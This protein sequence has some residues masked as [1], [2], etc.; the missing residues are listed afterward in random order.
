M[1]NKKLTEKKLFY[2]IVCFAGVVITMAMLITES[3]AS[4]TYDIS[5]GSVSTERFVSTDTIV[6]EYATQ[7]LKDEAKNAVSPLYTHDPQVKERV[8]SG[9][10]TFFTQFDSYTSDAKTDFAD[11][12]HAYICG[13]VSLSQEQFFTLKSLSKENFDAFKNNVE[14]VTNKVLDQGIRED[15]DKNSSLIKEEIAALSIDDKIG[16]IAAHIITSV[17]EPNLVIDAEATDR[18]KEEAAEAVEPVMILKDQK[19]VDKG[20]IVTDEIYSLL[21]TLGYVKSNSLSANFIPLS[22]KIMFILAAFLAA[23]YYMLTYHREIIADKRKVI[24]LLCLYIVFLVIVRFSD[25]INYMLVPLAIFPFLSALLIDSSLAVVLNAFSVIIGCFI[26]KGELDFMLY[27]LASGT[28][29]ALVTNMSTDRTNMF[30]TGLFASVMN[31][32]IAI[33]VTLAFQ[34]D[35]ASLIYT[36]ILYSFGGSLLSLIFSIGS[37]P[38]WEALFGIVSNAKLLELINPNKEL[39][40]RLLI[41]APGTYHHSLIV[42]NLSEAAACDIGANPVL[43]RVGAY[44]H[45]IGKLK[46]PQYFSENIVGENL[47]DYMDPYNSAKIILSH[48]DD[49]IALA[50]K[51]K[52]PKP[53][54]EIII[55]HH[56]NT[57]IKFFYFKAVKNFGEENV[58]QKDFRYNNII[59]Q[60]REAAVVML[61]D[62]AEA[63]VRSM[64]PT[65]KTMAEIESFVKS[66][67]KDKLDDGQLN[68]SGL[69]IK[70]LDVIAGSFMGIFKGMYHER[71]PYPE[72]KAEKNTDE[73]SE[74]SDAESKNEDKNEDKKK[75]KADNNI[76]ITTKNKNRNKPKTI[77]DKKSK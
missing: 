71:I 32:I 59:P 54:K 52:L 55:Q 17:I 69:T 74:G 22:G 41:E 6:N 4:K 46:N 31:C 19:I 56:G 43:A 73:N 38:I 26:F 72:D 53:V 76:N 57:L 3:Y 48:I 13:K 7:K 42:A 63:A 35:W 65:G 24:L 29:F 8:S 36:N 70:D 12:A 20:E 23:F 33:G 30:F 25:G 16:E 21:D 58:K 61:A 77:W 37:L 2:Y 11:D 62:T 44:Y 9:L 27:F 15:S 50:D 64:I 45:D 47:H 40:R 39:L 66:L 10:D 75:E 49:G 14:S 1:H 51:I 5:V 60:S 67:I 34:K 18:A 68:D 28:I